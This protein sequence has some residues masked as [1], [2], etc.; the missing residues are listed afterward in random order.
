M[1]LD[2]IVNMWSIGNP[3]PS[4]A[5]SSPSLQSPLSPPLT[6]S[7]SCSTGKSAWGDVRRPVH[8]ECNPV[9]F[10][11]KYRSAVQCLHVQCNVYGVVHE[12][13]N[14]NLLLQRKFYP[15]Q[16]LCQSGLAPHMHGKQGVIGRQ[17]F[18]PPIQRLASPMLMLFLNVEVGKI[19]L[20]RLVGGLFFCWITFD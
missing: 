7:S 10:S 16:T 1:L 14:E 6:S 11:G 4:I 18:D 9:K 15:D 19:K 2:F 12:N 20:S 3:S 17:T 13:L 8:H 5:F